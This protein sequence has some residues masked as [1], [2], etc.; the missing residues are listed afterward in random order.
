MDTGKFRFRWNAAV[1][2]GKQQPAKDL[3]CRSV[4]VIPKSDLDLGKFNMLKHNIK[5]T[6]YQ[7]LN[8]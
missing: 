1:D 7:Y 5:F 4:D 2:T 6:D 8:T 3:L